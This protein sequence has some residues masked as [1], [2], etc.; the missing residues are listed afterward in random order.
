MTAPLRRVRPPTKQRR[1]R[2]NDRSGEQ[3]A[4]SDR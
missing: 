1:Q 4:D 3:C 2:A